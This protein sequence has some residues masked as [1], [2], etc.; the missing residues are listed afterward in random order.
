MPS[1]LLLRFY[2]VVFNY[3]PNFGR[4]G[5]CIGVVCLQRRWLLVEST[6]NIFLNVGFLSYYL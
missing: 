6:G 5:N 4:A 1:D 2:V 3:Y